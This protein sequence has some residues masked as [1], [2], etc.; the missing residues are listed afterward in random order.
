MKAVITLSPRDYGAFLF[1]IDAGAGEAALSIP[2]AT[3]QF[4]FPRLL[5]L[6]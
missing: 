3:A 2:R 6:G 4:K 1:D 5:T